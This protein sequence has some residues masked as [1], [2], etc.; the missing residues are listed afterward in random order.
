MRKFESLI[1]MFE[2]IERWV[3]I[4]GPAKVTQEDDPLTREVGFGAVG[5]CENGRDVEREMWAISLTAIKRRGGCQWIGVK[6]AE[7]RKLTASGE[8]VFS[9]SEFGDHAAECGRCLT[10]SV[11]DT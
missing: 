9:G 6:L 11:H 5:V 8:V 1:A 2:D 7:I 4:N 3:A 10:S